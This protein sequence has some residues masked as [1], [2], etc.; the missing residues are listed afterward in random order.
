MLFHNVVIQMRDGAFC[1]NGAAVHDVEAVADV[2]TEVEVLLDPQDS[3][4]ALLA[5]RLDGVADLASY[6][7]SSC[8]SPSVRNFLIVSPI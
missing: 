4:L 7:R 6:C 3:N 5:K 2:E 1:H 8:C